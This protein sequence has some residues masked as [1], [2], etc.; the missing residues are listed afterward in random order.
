MPAL[1]FREL[2][3]KEMKICPHNAD[4]Y[5]LEFLLLD[6]FGLGVLPNVQSCYYGPWISEYR[7]V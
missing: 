7:G 2:L 5:K 4:M 6:L 3:S 1:E